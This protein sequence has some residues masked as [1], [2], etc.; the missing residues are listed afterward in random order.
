MR[1]RLSM[2]TMN[3]TVHEF[4]LPTLGEMALVIPDDNSGEATLVHPQEVEGR[5]EAVR[6]ER[7]G[8]FL[9]AIGAQ[10]ARLMK[11][12]GEA[13]RPSSP[14]RPISLPAWT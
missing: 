9:Y 8:D 2:A 5:V 13:S 1:L 12:D 6:V 7:T 4:G 3:I 10:H 14:A 11:I